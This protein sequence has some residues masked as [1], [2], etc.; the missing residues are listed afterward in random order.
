[1]SDMFKEYEKVRIKKSGIVGEIIDIYYPQSG[2]RKYT[3]ESDEKGVPGG[4]GDAD[5]WKLFDCTED[6]LERID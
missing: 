1:M 6:D 2:E 4:W 3:V 5:S